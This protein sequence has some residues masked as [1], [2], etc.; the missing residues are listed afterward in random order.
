MSWTGA[1]IRLKCSAF[2]IEHW[3][4]LIL[5]ILIILIILTCLNTWSELIRVCE[6]CRSILPRAPHHADM[7]EM[8]I[9]RCLRMFV[10]KAYRHVEIEDVGRHV[11]RVHKIFPSLRNS[12]CKE[13]ANSS[14]SVWLSQTQSDSVTV[15]SLGPKTPLSG[16]RASYCESSLATGVE[17]MSLSKSKVQKP[18]TLC[19]FENARG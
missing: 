4:T 14:D 1:R 17:S 11:E 2:R 5:I 12:I 9:S 18:C 15:L 3:P 6:D 13:A 8:L 7:C 19:W 16:L 10:P